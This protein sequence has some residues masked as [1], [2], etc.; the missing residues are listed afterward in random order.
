MSKRIGKILL[1]TYSKEENLKVYQTLETPGI[2]DQ[3]WCPNK[4]N[5]CSILGVATATGQVSIYTLNS[6]K[7]LLKLLCTYAVRTTDVLIL[8]LDWSSGKY[9]S[10]EPDIVCS[11]SK[12]CLHLL[13]FCENNLELVASWEGHNSQWGLTFEA[14]IAGFYYWDTNTFFSGKKIYQYGTFR[15]SYNYNFE[16]VMM[17]FFLCMTG[18]LKENLLEKISH[19]KLGL[20]QFIPM[21]TRSM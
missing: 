18:E 20:Q 16:V 10:N 8:S 21:L 9:S 3:K 17:G 6:E 5:E 19:I 4:L 7:I 15:K 13:R 14:W 1:F 11:D 12:G 2:L